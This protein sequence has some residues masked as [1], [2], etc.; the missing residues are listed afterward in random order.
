MSTTSEEAVTQKSAFDDALGKL[1]ERIR[2]YL[3]VRGVVFSLLVL[4]ASFWLAMVFD[5][6]IFLLL[7]W[8]WAQILP[9]PVRGLPVVSMVLIIATYLVFRVILPS[10]AP[11]SRSGLA[12][13][14]EHRFPGELGQQLITAVDLRDPAEGARLGYSADLV[15][16]VFSQAARALEQTPVDQVLNWRRMNLIAALA[17][18]ACIGPLPVV[19]AA[20]AIFSRFSSEERESESESSPGAGFFE[21]SWLLFERNV[22]LRD[23]IWP[24]KSFL[25]MEGF[26]TS[27]EAVIG[28]DLG[29]IPLRVRAVRHLTKGASSR[30]DAAAITEVK[31]NEPSVNRPEQTKRPGLAG[32]WPAEGWRPL[33]WFDLER[34][35]LIGSIESANLPAR[36]MASLKES[37]YAI[38]TLE[39]LAEEAS[40][41]GVPSVVQTAL[42]KLRAI[43]TAGSHWAVKRM[44]MPVKVVAQL[45]TP[46]STSTS[47]MQPVGRHEFTTLVKDLRESAT[48]TIRGDDY[49]TGVRR[50]RVIPPPRLAQVDVSE[51]HPAYLYYR[52]GTDDATGPSVQSL[53]G[54]RQA[55]L[56]RELLQPGSDQTRLIVPAGSTLSLLATADRPLRD[57]RITAETVESQPSEKTPAASHRGVD[58][59]VSLLDAARFR[60][61]MGAVT[62]ETMLRLEFN[63]EEGVPGSRRIVLK[64][65]NDDP[66]QVKAE[67]SAFLR[68]TDQGIYL[69]TPDARIPFQG[70]AEDRQGLGTMEHVWTVE[71]LEGNDVQ[72]LFAAAGVARVFS[73]GMGDG[74]AASASWVLLNRNQPLTQKERQ[75]SRRAM[76]VLEQAIERTPN[77]RLDKATVDAYLAKAVAL[78]FRDR[79]APG[80]SSE[81]Q[82]RER[83]ALLRKLALVPDSWEKIEEE[84]LADFLMAKAGIVTPKGQSAPGRQRVELWIEAA[85]L[86]RDPAASPGQVL[87]HRSTSQERFSFLVISEDDLLAEV[88]KDE[89]KAQDQ[90]EAI[91]IRLVNEGGPAYLLGTALERKDDAWQKLTPEDWRILAG[92]F[93]RKA[94]DPL[95]RTMDDAQKTLDDLATLY[96][97]L[98]R[99]LELNKVTEKTIVQKRQIRD[100]LK[101]LRETLWPEARSAIEALRKGVEADESDANRRKILVSDTTAKLKAVA[102]MMEDL[103]SRMGG[104]LDFDKELARAREIERAE[105]AQYD[106]IQKLHEELVKRTLEEALNPNK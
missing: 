17:L 58:V 52:P 50:I 16:R 1:R 40:A 13:L 42:E 7:G 30:R 18:F 44:K 65:I 60:F 103:L 3:I 77:E 24:R 98:V 54:K 5:R 10:M 64:P 73:I 69:V 100:P 2:Q 43:E 101:Q 74:L 84:P 85:D 53:I 34:L 26:P 29:Q 28:Q 23:L 94:D 72:S 99:E 38:D 63:D 83:Q 49:E 79:V 9:G 104:V 87:P 46:G 51:E 102:L 68:R 92:R 61:A 56:S 59:P 41:E 35:G 89:T 37:D 21:T 67:P 22:L 45:R 106:F 31:E 15:N 93:N 47:P 80:G 20:G 11:F 75:I 81:S 48:F 25:V 19:Y 91:R 76:P 66:P 39:S 27:G 86:D 33:D 8:D 97:N 36:W 90:L 57:I 88:R 55:F 6:G 32:G 14:M 12:L 105:K 71:A 4:S 82:P 62:S 95:E 96:T 70:Q 78:P